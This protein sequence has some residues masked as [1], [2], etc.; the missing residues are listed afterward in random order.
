MQL[1]THS[2]LTFELKGGFKTTIQQSPI[3]IKRA[4]L[5]VEIDDH[6]QPLSVKL[7]TE[8]VPA[9]AQKLAALYA[10]I[11][12]AVQVGEFCYDFQ[13]AQEHLAEYGKTLAESDSA[14]KL[15]G[16]SALLLEHYVYLGHRDKAT[17]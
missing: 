15:L 17:F 9:E 1:E 10:P 12:Q 8:F 14:F 11:A 2:T 6:E 5:T 3:K 7:D 13:M 4:R 16:G